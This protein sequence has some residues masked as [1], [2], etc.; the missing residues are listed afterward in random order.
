[1]LCLC[2]LDEEEAID[3]FDQ[4]AE[5]VRGWVDG[6]REVPPAA[7]EMLAQLFGQLERAEAMLDEA[8]LDPTLWNEAMGIPAGVERMPNGSEINAGLMANLRRL[9][10]GKFGDGTVSA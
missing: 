2:G 9:R 10:T 7:W 5:M 8:G 6:S 4:P 1:M 3:F